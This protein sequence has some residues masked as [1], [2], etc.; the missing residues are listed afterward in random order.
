MKIGLALGGG[1][2]KG[3]AHILIL[4][5][6]YE[7]GLQPHIIAGT[8]SGAI[9]GGL[10]ASGL[11]ATEIKAGILRPNKK[12]QSFFAEMSAIPEALRMV[13][14]VDFNFM[15]GKGGFVKGESFTEFYQDLLPIHSFS[16]LK[17]PLKVVATDFWERKPVILENGEIAQAVKASMAIPVIFAPVVIEEQVLVDGGCVNPVPYDLIQSQCDITIAVDVLGVRKPSDDRFPGITDGIFNTYQIMSHNIVLSKLAYQ[18]PDIYLEPEIAG[19]RMFEFYR[20]TEIFKQAYP[21]KDQF[22]K[23]LEQLME[24]KDKRAS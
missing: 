20:A 7:L 23:A 5:V 4:E 10:Y 21:V 1:G 6:W 13:N 14:F 12:E 24:S 8:S 2:A 9:V 17:I 16:E 3:L 18:R 22:K 11:S 15:G 19:I